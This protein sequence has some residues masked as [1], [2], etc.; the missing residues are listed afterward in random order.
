MGTAASYEENSDFNSE[1]TIKLIER[2]QKGDEEAKSILVNE[3]LGLVKSLVSRF[4]NRGYDREDIF[5]LGCI[6]LIKAIEKFDTSYGVRFSTYA[7]P[8][9]IGEIKRFLRD[10]GIIKV[11]RSLKQTA[12][13]VKMTKETLFK[14]L[15]REPTIQEISKELNISKED[16]VL[17]L[18]SSIHPD[19]LYD[20]IHEDDGSP[21]HLIDKISETNAD[22]DSEIIDRIALKDALNKLKPRERQIIILRYFKDKTQ[23]D[24][25]K[26][27][28][29]SQVQVSRIE[30][31]V[32]ET[33]KN[34]LEKT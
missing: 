21:I 1:K 22:D 6:G 14:K 3:N 13:K 20:I 11:S 8:M 31:K 25:A 26:S 12:N 23:S 7:V 34:I 30:K 19:Y 16:I 15:G 27:L 2:A 17:A 33:M 28:G 18:E 9:I 24:I 32:L 10:D 29:I 4:D 5:Q